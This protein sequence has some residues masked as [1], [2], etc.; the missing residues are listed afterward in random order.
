MGTRPENGNSGE[1]RVTCRSRSDRLN[2]VDLVTVE[3]E[4]F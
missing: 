3:E 4:P 1:M 2:A